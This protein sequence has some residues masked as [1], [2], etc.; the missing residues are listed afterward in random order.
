M[1]RP[2]L[3]FL[4]AIICTSFSGE[5][6]KEKLASEG[7]V[8][9]AA[10]VQQAGMFSSRSQRAQ[11][12]YL[13]HP[14]NYNAEPTNAEKQDIRFIVLTLANRSVLAIAKEKDLVERAGDRI[15]HLHPLKFLKCIFT[16]D[17]LKVGIKNIREKSWLWS[18]FIEGLAVTLETES[19]IH[20]VTDEMIVEFSK[21]LSLQSHDM[22]QLAQKGA[23]E[24]MVDYMIAHVL[25]DRDDGNRYDF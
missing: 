23:W 15:D 20:N 16:D 3:V 9:F 10:P 8:C 21:Q 11:G 14:R 6:L 24:K 13:G 7:H 12:K 22:L 5:S 17:E 19:R 18:S 2:H 1:L 25:R 4:I